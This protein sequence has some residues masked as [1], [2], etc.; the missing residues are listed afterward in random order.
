MIFGMFYRRK[1]QIELERLLRA[2]RALVEDHHKMV[3]GAR[4]KKRRDQK[5]TS[6]RSV[7]P[8]VT[9]GATLR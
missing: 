5:S 7:S 9:S 4:K 8:T 1:A 6:K 2:S 3:R